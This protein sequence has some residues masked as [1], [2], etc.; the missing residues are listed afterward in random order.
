MNAEARR[1]KILKILDNGKAVTASKLAERFGVTRQIIVSDI[2]LL[3]SAGNEIFAGKNGYSLENGGIVSEI[4]VCR[5]SANQLQQELYAIVDNGGTAVDEAVEHPAYGE[6]RARMNISS[7]HDAD[8]FLQTLRESRCEPLCAVNGGLHYHTV[9]A[10]DRETL[11]RIRERLDS[12]GILASEG[13][14]RRATPAWL[15]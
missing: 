14:S 3:R 7:R 6:I 11:E 12:L 15:F 1:D 4:F 10:A 9:S 13:N 8:V 5:H 2:A